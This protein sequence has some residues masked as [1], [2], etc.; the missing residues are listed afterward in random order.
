M[1]SPL[2]LNCEDTEEIG[3]RATE[4]GG[5]GGGFNEEWFND[6][7]DKEL[8]IVGWELFIVGEWFRGAVGR[9]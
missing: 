6:V 3:G 4:D 1:A 9:E 2:L 5:S 7:V 8:F